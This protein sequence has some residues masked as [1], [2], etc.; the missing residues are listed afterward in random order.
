MEKD[1]VTP[2]IALRAAELNSRLV[3]KS[4]IILEYSLSYEDK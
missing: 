3:R 1:P 4:D 2:N